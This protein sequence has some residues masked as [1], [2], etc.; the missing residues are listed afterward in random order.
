MVRAQNGGDF[1][2]LS[3]NTV[4]HHVLAFCPLCYWIA[5]QSADTL[6]N[7]H[8]HHSTRAAVVVSVCLNYQYGRPLMLTI[9]ANS[10]HA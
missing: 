9:D 6:L 2:G 5:R 8:T 1:G 7:T 4:E 3:W 10:T